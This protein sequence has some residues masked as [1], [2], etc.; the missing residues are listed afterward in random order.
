VSDPKGTVLLVDDSATI[1]AVVGEQLRSCGYE[2]RLASTGAEALAALDPE[3]IAAVLLDLNLPDMDGYDVCRIFKRDPRTYHV[4][5][6][7]LTSMAD[8]ESELAAI[9]AGADDFITKPLHPRILEARLHMHITR[10]MRERCANPLTGLP[11]NTV[12]EQAVADRFAGERPWSLAYIDLDDFKSYNDRYG[13]QRGD[14][15]I[16]LAAGIIAH[17]LSAD[18]AAGDFLG[19]IGGDDFVI[20]TTPDRVA[21]VCDRIIKSFDEAVPEYYDE[22]TRARGWF[23]SLD[24]RGHEYHVPLMSIS[25]AS[26]NSDDREFG[27]ALEVVDAVTELK[28]HAKSVRGSVH[29]AE[30]RRGP[31]GAERHA[32]GSG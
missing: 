17:A 20:M 30:R 4:P 8:T 18:G 10:S 25:I 6:I 12:I 16:L 27:T 32:V 22:A 14:A 9:D 11:G 15:M 23:K 1:R 5:V 31:F 13:Y 29:V 7:I 26:V 24:R 21:E 19:H 28:H 2:P 3:V